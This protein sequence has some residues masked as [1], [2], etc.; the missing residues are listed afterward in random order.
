MPSQL[1]LYL[2][3]FA[4]LLMGTSY[5]YIGLKGLFSKRPFVFSILWMFAPFAPIVVAM[6][7]ITRHLVTQPD[8]IYWSEGIFFIFL[9]SFFLFLPV[10]FKDYY[11]AYGVDEESFRR[12]LLKALQKLKIRYKES[13]SH[14]QLEKKFGS[15]KA[16]GFFL[17]QMNFTITGGKS[18][19]TLRRI[20]QELDRQ[21]A[22]SKPGFNYKSTWLCLGMALFTFFLLIHYWFRLPPHL[23]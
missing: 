8:H 18:K 9:F 17:G 1:I 12:T 21:W 15:L 10:Y 7:I 5:L 16:R 6:G 13:F 4:I 11:V 23:R 22:K 14:L 3:L 19:G 2:L 20:A